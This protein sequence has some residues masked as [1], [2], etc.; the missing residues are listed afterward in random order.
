MWL[1]LDRSA[2]VDAEI[3]AVAHYLRRTEIERHCHPYVRRYDPTDPTRERAT[4]M[5]RSPVDL[6]GANLGSLLD[7]RAQLLSSTKLVGA[8]LSGASLVGSFLVGADLRNAN[9][10]AFAKINWSHGVADSLLIGD[11]PHSHRSGQDQVLGP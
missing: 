11:G 4:T 2:R 6:R 5:P 10:R 7:R 9:L 8:D 3:G 1:A